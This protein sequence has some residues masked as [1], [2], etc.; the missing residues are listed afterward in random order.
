ME[1]YPGA[2]AQDYFNVEQEESYYSILPTT[3]AYARN[4]IF[5]GMMPSDM[6]KYHPDLWVRE[7]VEDGKNNFE[8]KFLERQLKKLKAE[9]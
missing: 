3:T 2:N 6:E 8:D 9:P 5:S 1:N 7:D 4:A